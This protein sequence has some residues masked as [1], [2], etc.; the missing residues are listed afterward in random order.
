MRSA[1]FIVAVV[2]LAG[3]AATP[4][5]YYRL[6]DIGSSKAINHSRPP[7]YLQVRLSDSLS[8]GSLV[9]QVS[10]TQ[11]HFARQHQWADDLAPAIAGQLANALNQRDGQYHY[12]N[13]RSTD[14]HMP[15]LTVYLD[16]FEGSHTGHTRIAGYSQWSDQPYP[17]IFDIRTP[18]QGDGHDAMVHTL[19]EG[20]QQLATELAR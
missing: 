16:H 18:Q 17:T 11:V 2:L 1:A 19:A 6:P 15:V 20:L 14:G 8:S 10:P 13:H 7:A 12:V 3:C 5:Q 4:P 9:Y